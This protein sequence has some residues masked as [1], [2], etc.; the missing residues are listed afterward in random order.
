LLV[1]STAIAIDYFAAANLWLF[2][3]QISVL[4]ASVSLG[5]TVFGIWRRGAMGPRMSQLLVAF[6][7]FAILGTLFSVGF[8]IGVARW[9]AM[10][11]GYLSRSKCLLVQAGGYMEF[12]F[13]PNLAVP[14]IILG[15]GLGNLVSLERLSER[16][17]CLESD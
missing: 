15:W 12:Y 14:I 17:H 3:A 7:M 6:S 11:C 8:G 13:L 16:Q 4:L 2:F 9:A 10:D 5:M 1:L